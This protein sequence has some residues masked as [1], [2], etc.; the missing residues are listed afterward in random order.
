MDL[1][2][3]KPSLPRLATNLESQ[4]SPSL[5]LLHR[6]SDENA[7]PKPE[8][9]WTLQSPYPEEREDT[10]LPALR[11][12]PHKSVPL[13]WEEILPLK[14]C[15]NLPAPK[16]KIQYYEDAFTARGAHNS[17][18][19][20]V[21]QDSIVVIEVKTNCKIKD[22]QRKLVGDLIFRLAQIYQRPE[23]S[24]ML[25]LQQ[26]AGVFFGNITEPSY[27]L[28]VY[29]LPPLIAPFTNLRNTS[30][31]QSAMQDLLHIPMERGVVIYTPVPEDNLANNGS[32]ARGEIVRLER[33]EQEDS[34][35]LFKT[36]SRSMSRRLKNTSSSGGSGPISLPS[37]AG[38]AGTAEDAKSDM[39]EEYEGMLKEE[40]EPEKENSQVI[41]VSNE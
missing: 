11:Y 2:K 37:T 5:P 22:E 6:K 34:P 23:T 29:A 30:L 19:D 25:T 13:P 10:I 8:R 41:K 26:E 39:I 1:P 16:K 31:I 7:R 21:A 28:K 18:Q 24:I 12:V 9:P 35:G 4:S 3:K 15:Q 33:N 32:T 36:I 17:P 27:L 38:T 40:K 14:D 20:R